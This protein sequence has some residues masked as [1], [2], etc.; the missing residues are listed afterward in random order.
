MIFGI[1]LNVI[2]SDSKTFSGKRFMFKK[3][4][5]AWLSII[6]LFSAVEI[7]PQGKAVPKK[8][9]SSSDRT[10]ENF[11]T[12]GTRTGKAQIPQKYFSDY[13]ENRNPD[14]VNERPEFFNETYRK[15]TTG[16]DYN[17]NPRKDPEYTAYSPNY[18]RIDK[19][20]NSLW[21]GKHWDY[22]NF[23]LK[24]FIK[25]SSSSHYKKK[26]KEYINYA[27]KIWEAADSRIKFSYSGSAAN[28]DIIFSFENNLMEKYEENYLGLTDYELGKNNRIIRSFVEIGLLKFDNRKI[29]DGEIKATIIHEL[30][31]A[32]GL[33]HS[34]NNV[35]L[36]YPYINAESSD[37][38]TYIELSKGDIEAIKSVLNLTKRNGYSS[39]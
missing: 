8:P 19:N 5:L 1:I 21:N 22:S 14:K 12:S 2:V 26:Y 6:I 11:F 39:K 25:E 33:G 34:G 10:T 37:K 18:F 7:T 29:S 38:F 16:T 24:V 3:N 20:E 31:H 9:E 35:D 27:F 36:M 4:I 28:A 17:I 13:H 32:L 30:G 23:P 15:I